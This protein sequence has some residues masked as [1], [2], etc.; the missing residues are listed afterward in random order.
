[1]IVLRRYL[2]RA[3]NYVFGGSIQNWERDDDKAPIKSDSEA[4]NSIKL[5]YINR[6]DL[7]K[8]ENM[9]H[10]NSYDEEED[11]DERITMSQHKKQKIEQTND[12]SDD[13]DDNSGSWDDG[14]PLN[15]AIEQYK[16]TRSCALCSSY[17]AKVEKTEDEMLEEIL[18]Q[19]WDDEKN[20]DSAES[21]IELS[22]NTAL[23]KKDLYSLKQGMWINDQIIYLWS[24]CLMRLSSAR[25]IQTKIDHF[26]ITDAVFYSTL[27]HKV[28]DELKRSTIEKLAK[29]INMK[30]EE[31]K[32][33][34]VPINR[35][36]HWSFVKINIAGRSLE[37]YDSKREPNGD[38]M[39][40]MNVG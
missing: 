37:Y 3:C 18:K 31:I 14:L 34:Y 8:Q 36:S 17:A 24:N 5:T 23:K 16:E 6:R 29:K 4:T 28:K 22:S 35:Q 38:Y 30:K 20:K 11:G 9:D 10:P 7:E 27:E 13:D 25:Q 1:M 21:V 32:V 39:D 2:G 40:I 33:V 26:L 15:G 12:D 19:V